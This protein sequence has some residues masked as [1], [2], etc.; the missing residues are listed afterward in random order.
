[1]LVQGGHK[2]AQ[3]VAGRRHTCGLGKSGRAYC[4]G[5]GGN[6]QLGDDRGTGSPVPVA[7]AGG[8]KFVKLAATATSSSTCGLT[9]EGEAWCWGSNRS[10]A[11]GNGTNASAALAPTQVMTGMRFIALSIGDGVACG[12][13]RAGQAYCWGDNRYGQ[14]GVGSAGVDGGLAGSNSPLAVQGGYTFSEVA[15]D[16]LQACALDNSGTVFC[17][18]LR[19]EE[20]VL[21]KLFGAVEPYYETL[22][23]AMGSYNHEIAPWNSGSGSPWTSISMG[24]GQVCA[25]ADNGV[26]ECWGQEQGWDPYYQSPVRIGVGDQQFS[27]FTSGGRHDC[28]LDTRG[29]AYCWGRN[30]WGQ[31]GQVPGPRP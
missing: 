21:K 8:L 30:N 31:L 27:A 2:F 9:A 12:V 28:A 3:L 7:V 17:W 1:M 11:L 25:R 29:T 23:T 15:T 18:G 6:G 13:N 10:G 20:I 26:L 19:F 5:F 22:P 14:I 24:D 16:G 4:W